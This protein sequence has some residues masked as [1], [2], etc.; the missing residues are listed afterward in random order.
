MPN[1]KISEL[2]LASTPLAGTELVPVVQGGV[3]EQVSVANLTAGRA[4]SAADVT[5]SSLTASQVVLTDAGKKLVSQAMTGT[6]NVVRATSP[7]LVT[8]V[9]GTPTSVTLT[10]ATGLPLTTG[11]TGVLPIANGGT[12]LSVAPTNGQIDIGNGS[13]FTRATLTAGAGISITNGAGSVTI[14][15]AASSGFQDFVI[16]SYGLV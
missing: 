12:G 4:V 13:G 3:T 16:Q 8:P 7:T 11:V 5:V 14:T 6:G 15:N 2:P 9:L 1:V 10:N